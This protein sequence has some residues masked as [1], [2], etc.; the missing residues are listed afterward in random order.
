MIV[1]F[2]M[3]GPAGAPVSNPAL[4]ITSSA[5]VSHSAELLYRNAFN[6]FNR[7]VIDEGGKARY[8]RTS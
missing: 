5:Y 3:R 4:E 7:E 2:Y 6:Q 8:I 1:G